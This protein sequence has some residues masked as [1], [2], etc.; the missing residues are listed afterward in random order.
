MA[1]FYAF[2]AHGLFDQLRVKDESAHIVLRET[3]AWIFGGWGA[4]QMDA[5]RAVAAEMAQPENANLASICGM[6][7][8]RGPPEYRPDYMIIRGMVPRKSPQDWHVEGLEAGAAWDRALY[9]L[10]NCPKQ[11]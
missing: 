8:S 1:I 11:D 6:L 10:N 3:Q 5:L 7:A 2:S 4:D 9:E